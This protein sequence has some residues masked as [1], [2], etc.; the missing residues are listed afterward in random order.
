V[1]FEEVNRSPVL[2]ALIPRLAD[3]LELVASEPIRRRATLGGNVVNAS[4]IGDL[5]MLLL[6]LDASVV[7]ARG[8]ARRT[9]PLRRLFLAYKRLDRAADEL[10][11]HF[12]VPL[13]TRPLLVNFEKV[14]KRTHL[15]IASVNSAASFVVEDGVIR[16]A[17]LAAGGVAPIPLYLE[18]ASAALT[19]APITVASARAAAAAADAEIAPIS[20]VRGSAAYKRLLL[21]QL[22]FAHFHELF[23]LGAELV[24]EVTR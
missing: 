3:F 16:R 8:E 17:H 18:R 7:L 24:A 11:D 14:S 6:G 5:T 21:R 10:I 19:D 23:G 9:L 20:D 12:V 2:Q 1:S 4:P 22:L 13:P 15:D